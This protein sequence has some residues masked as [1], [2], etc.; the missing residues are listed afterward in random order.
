MIAEVSGSHKVTETFRQ[1]AQ[2]MTG[3]SE[4]KKSKP[5]LLSP[6]IQKLRKKA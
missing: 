4:A 1:L 2:L 3:R 5:G 6:F